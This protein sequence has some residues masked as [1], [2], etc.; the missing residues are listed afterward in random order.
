MSIIKFFKKHQNIDL[1]EERRTTAIRLVHDLTKS[2]KDRLIE[3]MELAWQADQK[4]MK[5]K[6]RDE[7]EVADIDKIEHQ[8]DI[9][10]ENDK[11]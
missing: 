6:T 5:V 4:F 11:K 9:I 7:K 3:G 1:V 10:K 2:D 8:M